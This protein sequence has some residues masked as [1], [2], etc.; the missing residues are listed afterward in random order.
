MLKYFAG[1]KTIRLV[2][3]SM[4]SSNSIRLRTAKAS[5]GEPDL[6]VYRS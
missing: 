1:V 3:S 5:V 6:G 4:N 2:Y